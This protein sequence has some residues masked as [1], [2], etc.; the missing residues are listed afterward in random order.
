MQA[1]FR[2]HVDEE[3]I[4]AALDAPRHVLLGPK[5]FMHRMHTT[6]RA[7]P[8]RIVLP[9]SLDRRVVQVCNICLC[10]C[11]H[12]WEYDAMCTCSMHLSCQK[13][14]LSMS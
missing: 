12:I 9:E 7:E 3:A 13:E 8:Q 4:L 14:Q 5:A 2:Q 1:I 10:M 6:C 11:Q